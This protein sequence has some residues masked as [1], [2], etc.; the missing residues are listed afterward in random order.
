MRLYV[1]KHFYP[2]SHEAISALTLVLQQKSKFKTVH[3]WRVDKVEAVPA[4]MVLIDDL[5]VGISVSGRVPKA[6]SSNP[7]RLPSMNCSIPEWL[8]LVSIVSVDVVSWKMMNA[9]RPGP[10]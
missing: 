3:I 2:S 7:T 5:A 1:R 4:A 9:A 8:E 10:G 6:R